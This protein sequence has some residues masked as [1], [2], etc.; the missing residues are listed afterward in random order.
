MG[1]IRILNVDEDQAARRALAMT[2]IARGFEMDEATTGEEALSRLGTSPDVVLL[3]TAL[4]DMSGIEACR[5]IRS[6]SDVAII[7][8]SVKDQPREHAAIFEAGA[9]QYLTKLF[10]LEE[11][12]VR[13]RAVVRRAP[14]FQ[15]R[16]IR[17]DGAEIHMDSHE[18][19]RG[20][21]AIHLT[22][23]EFKLLQ[24]LAEHAG[25]SSAAASGSLGAG[26]RK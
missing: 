17:L 4:P 19:R 7:A 10:D 15:L 16:V 18:V 26:L 1:P 11:L 8:F 12:I 22:G 14:T 6:Q 2:L 5:C 21:E 25:I 23:K 9:D 13:L 24:C 20:S 3:Q